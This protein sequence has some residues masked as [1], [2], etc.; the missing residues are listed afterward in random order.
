[1]ERFR[2]RVRKRV[3]TALDAYWGL[4]RTR[5]G[6]DHLV[7]AYERY[8]G[9]Q[10]SLLAASVTYYAFLSFFPLLALAFS[11]LGYVAA[12]DLEARAY[13]EQAVEETLPGLADRLPLEEVA[14]ARVGAGL[15]GLLGLL[16]A[17]LGAVSALREALRVIWLRSTAQAV[18]PLLGKLTDLLV[19]VVLGVALLGSVALTSAAQAATRWSL[20]WVGLEHTPAALLATRFL[21]LAIAVGVDTVL[22]LV[23]FGRLSGGGWSWRP[24]WRGAFFAALGFEALKATG[25]L[26]IRSTLDNPVYASF[27][28]LAGLLVWIDIVLRFVLFAAAWTATWLPVPPPYQGSVP[29][30]IPVAAIPAEPA[31]LAAREELVPHTAGPAAGPRSPGRRPAPSRFV[32][33]VGVAAAVAAG[34]LWARRRGRDVKRSVPR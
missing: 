3:N 24:L 5:P 29:I 18:N 14:R 33:A 12:V 10:G 2:D 21:G 26:L 8:S 25:A 11:L 30:D 28:V 20:S 17:G 7:R 6:F 27:A 1:M 32:T 15:L 13:L 4:R 16:Y 9:Q 31:R 22:F 19:V 23:V 34:V